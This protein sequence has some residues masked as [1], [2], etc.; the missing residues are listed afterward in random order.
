M[1]AAKAAVNGVLRLLALLIQGITKLF[2]LDFIKFSASLK[3]LTQGMLPN[4]ELAFV[5]IGKYHDWKFDGFSF[6]DFGPLI[7]NLG[8]K[9]LGLFGIPV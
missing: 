9:L 5:F 8:Y 1:E 3:K 6:N 2:H 7:L 4:L